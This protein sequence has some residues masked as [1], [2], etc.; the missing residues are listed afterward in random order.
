MNGNRATVFEGSERYRPSRCGRCPLPSGFSHTAPPSPCLLSLT[1]ELAVVFAAIAYITPQES[2]LS[3]ATLSSVTENTGRLL[4]FVSL[5]DGA[6]KLNIYPVLA[7]LP[8]MG[9]RE[10]HS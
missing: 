7:L 8:K 3:A 4:K 2:N 9:S 6:T 5:P 1:G 10:C